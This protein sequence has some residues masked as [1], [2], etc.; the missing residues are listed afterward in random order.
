VPVLVN[1]N[2]GD[3]ISDFHCPKLIL[4]G[5]DHDAAFIAAT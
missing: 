4:G 5:I 2:R 3:L 1:P